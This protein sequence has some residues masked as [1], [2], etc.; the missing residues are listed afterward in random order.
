MAQITCKNCGYPWATYKGC[1][2]C[3][4]I[5]PSGRDLE[6]NEKSAVKKAIIFL[7]IGI[8]IMAGLQATIVDFGDYIAHFLICI[9]IVAFLIF[10]SGIKKNK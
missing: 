9:I 4:D 5:N 7:I 1:S 10:S 8:L 2:N 3:G 6:P